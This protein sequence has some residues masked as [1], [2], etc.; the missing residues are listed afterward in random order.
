MIVLLKMCRHFEWMQNK[1]KHWAE[2]K[3]KTKCEC[4]NVAVL[5]CSDQMQFTKETTFGDLQLLL[6][7]CRLTLTKS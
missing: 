4:H 6:S 2:L 1:L 3:M 7:L 5:N